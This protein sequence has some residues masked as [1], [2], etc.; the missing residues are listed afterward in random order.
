MSDQNF[1]LFGMTEEDIEIT[2]TTTMNVEAA[3]P[4]NND[5]DDDVPVV[6]EANKE[7]LESVNHNDFIVSQREGSS[8]HDWCVQCEDRYDTR[9]VEDRGQI[10]PLTFFDH[11][12]L[13]YLITM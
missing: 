12:K 2:S 3:T 10:G 11:N 9:E 6:N 8:F 5:G 4:V 7:V 1:T 13:D